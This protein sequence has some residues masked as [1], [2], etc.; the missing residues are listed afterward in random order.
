MNFKIKQILIFLLMIIFFSCGDLFSPKKEIV[1]RYYLMEPESENGLAIY[2]KTSDGDYIGR[3][4]AKVLEYGFNDSFIV[5]KCE[6]NTSISYYL[7]Q[8]NLDSNY[9]EPRDFLAGPL[10]EKEFN[11]RWR[12]RLKIRFTKAE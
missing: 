12:S 8:R 10:S 3:I 1:G 6:K 2:Y 7:V 11:E 4:P 5:A 9:T